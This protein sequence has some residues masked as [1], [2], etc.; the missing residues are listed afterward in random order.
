MLHHCFLFT[1]KLKIIYISD[2]K[3]ID[4][5]EDMDEP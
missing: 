5:V 4:L 3:E 2:G 1:I